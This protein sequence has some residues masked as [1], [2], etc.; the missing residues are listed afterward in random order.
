MWNYIGERGW[1]I[2]VHIHI[3]RVSC[4]VVGEEAE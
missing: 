4:T 3:I 2:R 1:D